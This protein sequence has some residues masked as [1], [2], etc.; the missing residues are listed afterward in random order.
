MSQSIDNKQLKLEDGSNLITKQLNN[1]M[2]DSMMPYA[3]FV[4]LD[5]AL[6]RV[7]DGLKPVH[8]RILYAMYEL[9]MFPDKPYRKC[10]RIV[11]DCLGKYH[12][13]GDK[14][15]YDSLVRMAQDFSM[16]YPLID[17]Q[18]NFGS[19]DGDSSAAMRYTEARLKPLALELL[20]DIDL[21]T[22]D[23]SRNFDDTL[24]EPDMLP[25]RFPNLLVN[26][27]S[28]IAVG[29]ATNIPPHNLG[30]V[31]DACIHCIEHRSVNVHDIMKLLPGPDFP[32]GG[33]IFTDELVKAYET[34]KGKITMRAKIVIEECANDKKNIVITELP[35]QVNKADLLVKILELRED[36]KDLSGIAEI[37]DESDK[38]GIRAVIRVKKECDIENTLKILYK[39]TDLQCTFGINMVAIADGRPKQLGI[40]EILK[41]Y[42]KYQIQVIVRRTKFQLNEAKA[43][44]HI[45]QGLVIAVTNIDEVI[46][47]I[48]SS[49]ST[50]DARI[51]LRHAFDLSEKQ[52][53]AILD[54]RLARITKLE[55]ES[56]K[57]ELAQLVLLIKELNEILNSRIKQ[58]NILKDELRDIKRRHNNERR[59]KIYAGETELLNA[60][61]KEQR[62]KLEPVTLMLTNSRLKVLVNTTFAAHSKS[63]GVRTDVDNIP[64]DAIYALPSESVYCFTNLG[65]CYK[66]STEDIL[67]RKSASEGIV[68]QDMFPEADINE[69]IIAVSRFYE[70]E[71][72]KLVLT[73]K[74]GF[75]LCTNWSNFNINRTA[76]NAISLREDDRLISMETVDNNK[77]MLIVSSEGYVVK[78]LF[79]DVPTN[80]RG[81]G[82]VKTIKFSDD[83]AYV[84]YACQSDDEGE[85]I[86]ITDKGYAKRI[87]LVDIDI[88]GRYRKGLKAANID[89]GS[90]LIYA[91]SVK[92]PYNILIINGEET[93]IID[94][95][96]IVLTNRTAKGKSILKLKKG[97]TLSIHKI[98]N[99]HSNTM[100]KI[101]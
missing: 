20:R 42:V 55:V 95:E 7:E 76:F 51:K 82:G 54:L 74:Q 49:A 19:I 61:V 27:S 2:H 37:V 79:D 69:T 39:N 87:T 96:Q 100:P 17:G 68:L 80:G 88:T 8:R 64:K 45:L 58:D 83:S 86:L 14:S 72:D 44:E 30:E 92:V 101:S 16:R 66:I 71:N 15:V 24:K 23:F 41:Y 57:K 29:L 11:G 78:F 22:V 13:H 81:S 98:A 26:G 62:K 77:T 1:V 4:I 63:I 75:M 35:Y 18:G 21:D 38:E 99:K 6:P 85:L 65:N 36:N 48:K 34:G 33:Y 47:I 12:P 5:R 32:G 67:L 3:E 56:L 28:G 89:E 73:T 31:I 46:R 70:G 25:G 43:R 50:T 60:Q 90:Q 91:Q 53:Q 93:L 97:Q 52:A 9:G 94:S 84:T 10:A 40:I 59:T